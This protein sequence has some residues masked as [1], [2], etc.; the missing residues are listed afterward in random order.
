MHIEDV[1]PALREGRRIR[2]AKWLNGG[3]LIQVTPLVIGY[4][5]RDSVVTWSPRRDDFTADDWEIA[6]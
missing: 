3:G 5:D 1:L 4:F 2:R 6:P